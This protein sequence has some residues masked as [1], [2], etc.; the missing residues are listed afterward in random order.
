MPDAGRFSV[1]SSDALLSD[2][3]SAAIS[4]AALGSLRSARIAALVPASP[5]ERRPLDDWPMLFAAHAMPCS[6]PCFL[7]TDSQLCSM[8]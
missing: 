5:T 2:A 4:E 8:N 7:T 3:Y 1:P 6:A